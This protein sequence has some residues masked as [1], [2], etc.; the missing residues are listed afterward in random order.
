MDPELFVEA[1]REL[2]VWNDP[3]GCEVFEETT[4]WFGDSAISA[5]HGWSDVAACLWDGATDVYG[6]VA[7]GVPR[8]KRAPRVET[9][10]GSMSL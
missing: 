4:E 1:C 7:Q 8:V 9:S 10:V 2:E 5:T 6:K 3:E